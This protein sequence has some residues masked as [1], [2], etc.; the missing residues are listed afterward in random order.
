[1]PSNCTIQK[2]I[3]H[4]IY[5]VYYN[6]IKKTCAQEERREMFRIFKEAPKK[7]RKLTLKTNSNFIQS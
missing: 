2:Y 4:P 5:A 1:M 3:G 7:K 6:R